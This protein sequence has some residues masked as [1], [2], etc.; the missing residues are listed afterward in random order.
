MNY[1]ILYSG[2]LRMD[3]VHGTGVENSGC[4]VR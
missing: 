4:K 3:V 2:I 1:L